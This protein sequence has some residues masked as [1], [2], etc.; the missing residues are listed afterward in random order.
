MLKLHGSMNWLVSI[1]NAIEAK[2]FDA[3]GLVQC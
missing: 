2:E 1:F 3:T